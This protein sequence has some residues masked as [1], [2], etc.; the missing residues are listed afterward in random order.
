MKLEP[1]GD[2]AVVATLGEAIDPAT[3]V[4]VLNFA[5]AVAAAKA[6]GV[7]DIVPAYV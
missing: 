2:A 5:E 4:A 7:T 6:K 1:L 3:L